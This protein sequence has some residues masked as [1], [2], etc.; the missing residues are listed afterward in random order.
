MWNHILYTHP[1]LNNCLRAEYSSPDLGN[2][3]PVVGFQVGVEQ[4]G[5]PINSNIILNYLYTHKRSYLTLL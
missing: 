1:T 3:P 4:G 2:W 5:K